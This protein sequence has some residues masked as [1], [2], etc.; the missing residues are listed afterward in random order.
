MSARCSL[1]L[2]FSTPR[3]EYIAVSA[4]DAHEP[5]EMKT[6]GPLYRTNI[7]YLNFQSLGRLCCRVKFIIRYVVLR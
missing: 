4:A 6:R 7:V 3:G 2:Y 5:F 1:Y